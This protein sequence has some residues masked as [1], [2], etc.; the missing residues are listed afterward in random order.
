MS[1]RSEVIRLGTAPGHDA[2]E[3]PRQRADSWPLPGSLTQCT[4]A[5]SA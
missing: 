3:P 1:L 5:L 2:I 4:T